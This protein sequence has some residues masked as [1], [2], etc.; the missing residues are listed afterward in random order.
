MAEFLGYSRISLGESD[1]NH[2][3]A[4]FGVTGVVFRSGCFTV[5]RKLAM[6]LGATLVAVPS[7]SEGYV[8]VNI[9]F[10]QIK[11]DKTGG[12]AGTI[13]NLFWGFIRDTI[14]KNLTNMFVRWG[15]PAQ[16]VSV[17]QVKDSYGIKVGRIIFHLD[18]VNRWLAY[19]RPAPNLRV[20]VYSLEPQGNNLDLVLALWRD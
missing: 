13:A 12:M 19:K 1:C 18:H 20:A 10:D 16:T 14:Q 6:G 2:L 15:L 11:G 7:Y 8:I 5:S 3:L 4:R 17:D 9:P